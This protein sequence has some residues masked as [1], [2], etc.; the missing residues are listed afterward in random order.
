MVRSFPNSSPDTTACSEPFPR[1]K[2]YRDWEWSASARHFFPKRKV[3]RSRT[4]W[5]NGMDK[6]VRC[7]RI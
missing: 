3:R 6:H 1:N 2:I 5:N 4:P 7:R